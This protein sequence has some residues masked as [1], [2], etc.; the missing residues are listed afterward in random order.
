MH[1]E[2]L[3]PGERIPLAPITTLG[4][5][6]PAHRFVEVT[7]ESHIAAAHALSDEQRLP[8]LLLGG[9]SNLVI[10]DEGF[11]GIVIRPV[12]HAPCELI[13]RCHGTF[14]ESAPCMT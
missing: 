8:I 10:A 2:A 9:G 7:G 4:I 6:G 12:E 11:S 5:G 13:T 3:D 1:A 14:S